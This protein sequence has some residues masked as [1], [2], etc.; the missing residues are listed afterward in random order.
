[1]PRCSSGMDPQT[2]DAS[3]VTVSNQLLGGSMC[4]V[5]CC[6]CRYDGR[7]SQQQER[8]APM[9][10]SCRFLQIQQLSRVGVIWESG[11]I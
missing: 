10:H 8:Q 6:Y 4:A 9:V 3:L 11:C 5:H 2:D 7:I 1:M